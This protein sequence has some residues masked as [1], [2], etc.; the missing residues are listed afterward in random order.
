M[1]PVAL[2]GKG[3]VRCVGM[4]YNARW[5]TGAALREYLTT[6]REDSFLYGSILLVHEPQP[7]DSNAVKVFEICA[8]G[9]RALLGFVARAAARILTPLL[10]NRALEVQCRVTHVLVNDVRDAETVRSC[11]FSAPFSVYLLIC[12][13]FTFLYFPWGTSTNKTA[14]DG[15]VRLHWIAR[16]RE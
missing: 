3:N 16:I 5:P 4:N 7:T 10:K 1:A 2:L 6:L 12:F 14:R 8:N 9:E 15:G 11:H 13:C